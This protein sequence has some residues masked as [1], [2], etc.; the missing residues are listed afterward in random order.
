MKRRVLISLSLAVAVL[1]VGIAAPLPAA[2]SANTV[3]QEP[4]IPP[5]LATDQLQAGLT[6]D[7]E[8]PVGSTEPDADLKWAAGDILVS[9]NAGDWVKPTIAH[10]PNGDLFVVVEDLASNFLRTY[11]STD[12][13]WSWTPQ[14][15]FGSSPDS[16]NPSIACVEDGAGQRWVFVAYEVRVSDILR[17]VR[18]YRYDP[19][20]TAGGTFLHAVDD[21][22][23]TQPTQELVPRIVTDSIDY[24]DDYYLYVTYA[25]PTIDYYPVFFVQS[26]DGGD[27]WGTP[28]NITGGSENT[29]A[30]TRPTIAYGHDNLYVAF[31]KPG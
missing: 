21:I 20:S 16:R 30:S 1:L 12:D 13:G 10:A 25:I 9:N 8:L 24:P 22:P 31:T 11:I 15:W 2:D 29:S 26:T 6:I 18:V 14:K 17:D 7:V 5:L 28:D 23:W 27:T 3:K 19:D 4:V